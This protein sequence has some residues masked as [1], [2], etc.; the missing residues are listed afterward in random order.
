MISFAKP[1]SFIFSSTFSGEQAAFKIIL[2]DKSSIGK[3]FSN[4]QESLKSQ[5]YW[6][7]KAENNHTQKSSQLILLRFSIEKH[8]LKW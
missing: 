7:A 2:Y 6:Q 1:S 4:A 3:P 8:L 5:S